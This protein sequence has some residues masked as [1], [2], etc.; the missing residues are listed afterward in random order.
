MTKLIF[1]TD[2]F[3][4]R[5]REKR[6]DRSLRDLSDDL[7]IS[8]STLSRVENGKYPDVVNLAS[9]LGWLGDDPALYFEPDHLD[10]P[11][12]GQLRAAQNMSEGTTQALMEAIKVA[13]SQILE[14]IDEDMMA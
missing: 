11:I 12:I 4:Q 1:N 14:G 5:V 2:L 7:E 10:D 6:G 3:G 13:Y 9:L 8:I